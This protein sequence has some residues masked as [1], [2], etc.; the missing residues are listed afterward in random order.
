V[1][2]I[3]VDVDDGDPRT[4][5]RHTPAGGAPDAGATPGHE[6]RTA[7]EE[8]HA[9]IVTTELPRAARLPRPS[10]IMARMWKATLAGILARKVRLALTALAVLLGV[11]FVSGTYVL[12][13]T[14]QHALDRVFAQTA[15]GIDLVVRSPDPF[16]TTGPGQRTRIPDSLL[17]RVRGVDGVATADGVVHGYAQFVGREGR[18]IQ[19]GL[20][21]TL[22]IS[23]GATAG[24][25]PL[26]LVH[27]GKSRP[28]RA[29]GEVAM[30]A[31]TARKHGFKVG[32]R[33]KVLLQGPAERFRLVGLFGF[34]DEFDLGGV[35]F[36]AFDLRTA[37]RVFAAPGLLDA[38]DMTA[39]PGVSVAEL[40]RRVDAALGGAYETV[41]A[42]D[43]A[44]ENARP[45]HQ[46][47]D[48]VRYGLAGF[49]AVGLVVGS[50]IIFNTFTILVAQRTRE[51]GLLRALGASRRQVL[52]SVVS[53]AACVGLLA[54][55]A[56]LGVGILLASVL[57]DVVA[58]FGLDVPAASTVVLGRTVGAAV[59]TGVGVTVASAVYPALRASR[60]TPVAAIHEARTSYVAPL[61]RRAVVG[62]VIAGS[63]AVALVAGLW[64]EADDI[65]RRVAIVAIG[66]FL[67]F[68]GAVILVAT[69]ARRLS[70]L[71]GW[72]LARGEHVTGK[73]ARGNAMRNPRRTAATASALIVGL[74]LVS[75]V[76]IFA[77]S[78]KASIRGAVRNGIRADFVLSAK[79]FAAL[80]AVEAVSGLRLGSI[81][82]DGR[83]R[84]VTAADPAALGKV[85]DLDLVSGSVSS[86]SHGGI[87]LPQDEAGAHHTGAGGA[88]TVT[89][90]RSGPQTLPVVGVYRRKQFTG[91]FPVPFGVISIATH[92]A[93]F[94][95]VQQDTLVYAKA[96]P[97]QVSEARR[98][99]H[100]TLGQDFP[101]IEVRTKSGF[102]SM[103]E[104][105]VNQ[106]VAVLIALLVLSEII[107]VLGIINTLFLAVY[108]R[109]RELGLLRVVGMSRRQVR[110]MIRGE[111]VIIAVVGGII[112]VLVGIFWGWAFT[113]ALRHE[114]LTEFRVPPAQVGAFLIFAVLAGIVA[115]LL[116]AWRASRLDV[117]EAIAEE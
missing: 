77:D 2:R 88:V 17:Q 43:V 24:V 70:Q 48:F 49:A 109:T 91:G 4:F 87:L 47:L 64:V 10:S 25:G 19:N 30:D 108:E 112:G 83:L 14:L 113:A 101:N 66:A 34:G 76:A 82:V 94:G 26:R 44:D 53:E 45:L 51:L 67:A 9:G 100:D 33:V 22:G 50:F 85:L 42:Q 68:F 105:A 8:A 29:D 40:E 98:E 12:T 39:R 35:T 37:Q 111:S 55:A 58:H 104:D 81:D 36:A 52:T 56:G 11:A 13:D 71:V 6:R 73:L 95:G 27:D 15:V 21:P 61:G 89:F 38:V 96:R 92:E 54:A 107:A 57:L 59:A 18:S 93:S 5:G 60:T 114:G 117:L 63:G 74:S 97:G 75:L 78:T 80:P 72:P 110:S 69:F 41:R 16:N 90:P 115:A 28:P 65:F 116:P 46:G 79:Q 84:L 23:W 3:A 1:G 32:D 31:G 7:V 106:F 102:E 99:I 20:A 103:Q 62:T 86:L